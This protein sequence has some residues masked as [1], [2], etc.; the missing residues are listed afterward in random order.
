M[1]FLSGLV[2]SRRNIFLP[3]IR[4]KLEEETGRTRFRPI[5]DESGRY[6]NKT[7]N[8]RGKQN[9][10][11]NEPV[12]CSGVVT[13]W[14][15]TSNYRTEFILYLNSRMKFLHPMVIW[16]PTIQVPTM[17]AHRNLRRTLLKYYHIKRKRCVPQ[18]NIRSN[19][20]I[21]TYI[22]DFLLT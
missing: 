22:I 3:G 14:Y 6:R 15:H 12:L 7:A 17:Q 4:K 8:K 21:I 9:C 10:E 2:S 1:P 20:N 13:L 18:N 19:I 5:L 16:I 11:D